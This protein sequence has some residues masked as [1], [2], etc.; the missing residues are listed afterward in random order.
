MNISAGDYSWVETHKGIVDFLKKNK[1]NQKDLIQILEDIG[2]KVSPDKDKSRISMPLEEI[3]PFT[4]FSQI[5]KYKDPAKR[6]KYLQDI[7]KKLGLKEPTGESGISSVNPLMARLFPYKFERTDEIDRLWNFFY[8]AV[9]REITDHEFADIRKIGGIGKK[10][11]TQ[12]LF[13][14]MPAD[15]LPI[16]NPIIEYL[17][18]SGIDTSYDTYTD[19]RKIMADVRMKIKKPFYKISHDAWINRKNLINYWVFQGDQDNFDIIKAIQEKNLKTWSVNQHKK[20]IKKE[21]KAIVWLVGKEQKCIALLRVSSSVYKGK[22]EHEELQYMKKNKTSV[23]CDRVRVDIEHNLAD[24]PVTKDM[25]EKVSE[26]KKMKKGNQGTVFRATKKEYEAILK[27]SNY[28]NIR[29]REYHLNTIFYGPPGTGKTFNTII[30]SVEI[31]H[32]YKMSID[33]SKNEFNR[34]MGTQIEFITF[35]QNYSYEDFIQG[36]RPDVSSGSLRFEK[37]DGVFK[38]I[39]DRAKADKDNNYVLIIDEINRANISRVFGELVTLIEEDKRIGN[40]LAMRCTLPSGDFFEVPS[41]LY[42]IGTMNTA[43]KS[44][45]LLDIA[46]RRRF[47]FEA[48]YP[49][50]DIYGWQIHDVDILKKLNKKIIDKKGHDFQIGHSYFMKDNSL[51]DRMN[52]EVIPLLLEYFMNDKKEVEDIL[53]DS[54]FKIKKGAWPIEIEE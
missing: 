2:I 28:K 16:D 5:Y 15:Y 37:K 22:C 50:Y 14:I 48:M 54:G 27:L 19:Y 13:Y 1:N 38:K 32:G 51:K 43:D 10:N 36:L 53:K 39:A 49:L 23:Q 11:I 4:F 21:D 41:N 47:R 29:S 9:D 18:N 45:A 33:D 7:A 34:L 8:K 24:N 31:I 30:R 25:I 52:D 40:P 46:L 20:E 3:D 44:I 6:L 17:R 42:I 26:L 12:I 35:H